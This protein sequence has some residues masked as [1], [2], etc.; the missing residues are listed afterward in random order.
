M[1]IRIKKELKSQMLSVVFFL[2]RKFYLTFLK[3]VEYIL[4]LWTIL[5]NVNTLYMVQ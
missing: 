2:Q 5:Y 4:Q 1:C 3:F